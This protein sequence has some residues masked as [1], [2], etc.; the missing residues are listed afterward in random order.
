MYILLNRAYFLY[1]LRGYKGVYGIG[2][3][4]DD[5]VF[6]EKVEYAVVEGFGQRFLAHEHGVHFINERIAHTIGD[7]EF[8]EVHRVH[9]QNADASQRNRGSLLQRDA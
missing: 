1:V 3:S 7:E 6:A 8:L 4:S 9:V 5:K 2:H